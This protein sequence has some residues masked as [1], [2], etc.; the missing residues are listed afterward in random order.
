MGIRNEI[1]AQIIRDAVALECSKIAQHSLFL[2]RGGDF[3]KDS[4]SCWGDKD[5]AYSLS[6]GSSLFAGCLFDGGAT[7]FHYMRNGKNAYAIPVSFDQL[8]R[9]PFFVPTTHTLA[10]LFG[11]GEIFHARTKAWKDYDANKL[12]GMNMGANGHE[13]NH[14]IS[15]LSKE[16]L[17]AQF[18]TYKNKAVQL[19]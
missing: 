11:D 19:K 1:D 14:L 15:N 12:G 18:E 10:Q 9:S 4:I 17:Y 2:Y 13:R 5:K 6:F 8:T 3:Q 7:A 16:E